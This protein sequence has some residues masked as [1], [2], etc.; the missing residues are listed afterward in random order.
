M[1]SK[2]QPIFQFLLFIFL[3]LMVEVLFPPS[4]QVKV[5]HFDYSYKKILKDR[6]SL[7][8]EKFEKGEIFSEMPPG[9]KFVVDEEDILLS[10]KF[11]SDLLER[12]I[13]ENK[14]NLE[15]G[16]IIL[17]ISG[18]GIEI[19][20]NTILDLKEAEELLCN[21]FSE[22]FRGDP[23][24]AKALC[25]ISK[26]QIFPNLILK[27]SSFMTIPWGRRILFLLII[28]LGALYLRLWSKGESPRWSDLIA[29]SS[30]GILVLLASRALIEQGVSPYLTI[31]PFFAI[32]VNVTVGMEPALFFSVLLSTILGF[33][34]GSSFSVFVYSVA[35]GWTSIFATRNFANRYQ[36]YLVVF[37]V[38]VAALIISSILSFLEK[39]EV[40]DFP[41]LTQVSFLSA[42]LSGLLVLGFLPIFEKVFKVSTDFLLLELSNLNNPLLRELSTRAPGTFTH[43]I[44]VGN[45]CEAAAR[46]IGA[47]PLLARVAAYYHDIGKIKSPEYFIENQ[48][49][50]VNPH[51]S[52]P[53]LKSAKILVDHVSD[54]VE[55]AKKAGLP[56]EI[57]RI[58]E[59]HHGTSVMLPF[60]AKACKTKPDT[61]KELFRYPGPKPRTKEEA[62]CMLADSVEAAARSLNKPTPEDLRKLIWDIIERRLEDEQLDLTDLTRKD[63]GLIAQAFYHVLI[64][65]LHPRVEYPEESKDDKGDSPRE[66][67]D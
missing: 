33:Y 30:T 52:L 26:R 36:I 8:L 39:G 12:G 21:R 64:G 13:V 66:G 44:L 25:L 55:I 14:G 42:L 32:I 27:S 49:G 6:T 19:D 43:S 23:L 67:K 10:E 9:S 62:I 2:F 29:I 15:K 38:F 35:I 5:L 47:N 50:K 1:R 11:V 51:D 60:Y 46:A 48:L 63:L 7:L 16:R 65:V 45:L 59:T 24:K 31:L 40:F 3:V 57:I 20:R 61:E 17:E 34:A 37:F 56:K 22:I 53:P 58:I 41:A 18:R 28:L 4:G 54:G